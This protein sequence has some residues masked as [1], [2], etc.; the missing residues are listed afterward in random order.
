MRLMR[1]V[2]VVAM[3]VVA[4]VAL[5]ALAGA[6]QNGLETFFENFGQTSTEDR[7]GPSLAALR[8]RSRHL[9]VGGNPAYELANGCYSL[10]SYVTDGA[11]VENDDGSYSAP[12]E[13]T[14]DAEP[15]RLRATGLGKYLLYGQ[16]RD[17]MAAQGGD[18]RVE[19]EEPSD[20]TVWEISKRK[21]KKGGYT[22]YSR[23]ADKV[24]AADPDTGDLSLRC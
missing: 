14:A 19:D 16:G 5:P 7:R 8:E 1:I 23:D 24:V 10:R 11:V 13:E 6:H 15:F 21:A 2:R 18:V 12:A 4:L 3:A 9:Q 17:F 20:E 22:L